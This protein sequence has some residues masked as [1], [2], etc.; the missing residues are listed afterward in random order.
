V[1][2][3]EWFGEREMLRR[4]R[5]ELD[6]VMQGNAQDMVD[7]TLTRISEFVHFL[8]QREAELV[9]E[10]EAHTISEHSYPPK[11]IPPAHPEPGRL[12]ERRRSTRS[13]LAHIP[14]L[15][16]VASATVDTLLSKCRFRDLDKGEVLLTVGNPNSRL[17]VI[18]SGHVGVHLDIGER[19]YVILKTGE[20]VGDMSI[21]GDMKV[22]ANVIAGE[23]C[24]LMVINCNL[25]WE[26]IDTSP[27]FARNLLYTLA[28]RIWHSTRRQRESAREASLDPLTGLHNRRSFRELFL[29]QRDACNRAGVPLSLM[30]VDIDHFK[31]YGHLLGDEALCAVAK[32]IAQGIGEGIAARYGGEEFV[33][34]LPGIDAIA[35]CNFANTIRLQVR[36]IKLFDAAHREL[37]PITI[38]VGIASAVHGDDLEMLIRAADGA[39]YRAKHQGRDCVVAHQAQD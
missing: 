36:D 14:L 34:L 26:L 12:L 3:I 16:G 35:A 29:A 9:N 10:Y 11:D 39:L 37:P 27:E 17:Y 23:Q 24:R 15:R 7:P 5:E 33:A 18:M 21:L 30:M 2:E 38:S 28:H 4:L 32:A 22:T 13:T 25:V 6:R 19:P 20:C 8:A 1:N 31:Q